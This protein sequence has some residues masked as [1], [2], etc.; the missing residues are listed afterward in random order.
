MRKRWLRLAALPVAL[1]FVAAACG[2]DDDD[3]AA[4]GDGTEA[5]ADT[6][7]RHRAPKAPP[8]KAPPPRA[9]TA[10]GDGGRPAT[11][12]VPR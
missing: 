7:T 6:A 3:D 12:A 4:G 5:P 9:P 8:P 2:D 11:S 10:E 1:A